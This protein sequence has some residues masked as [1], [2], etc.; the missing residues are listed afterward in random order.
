[1]NLASK[2]LIHTTTGLARGRHVYFNKHK[3][4]TDPAKQDPDYFEKMARTLP[5]DDNYIDQ[6]KKIY[7]D[8]I[9]SE[10]DLTMKASD[11]LVADKITYGLPQ[12]DLSKPRP[13]YSYVDSLKDAPESVR[14]IFSLEFGTRRDV[15]SEWKRV[16]IESVNHHTLDNSSLE[17]KI[18]LCTALIRHWSMIVDEIFA[19]N[20]RPRKP[21]WLTHRIWLVIGQRR[22]LL[23]ELREINEESFQRVLKELKIAYHVQKQPE[24]VKTRKAWSEAQLL[25]RIQEEKEK[26]LE[27]LH[28]SYIKEREEK[29]VEMNERK[30]ELEKE[31]IDI[32]QRMK[33]LLILEGKA[34]D[35]VVGEYHPSLVGNM[36]ETVVHSML[37]YHPKPDMVRNN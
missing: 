6:L 21:S 14:K 11:N 32:E 12:L 5:L 13:P 18:A 35:N 31:K 4:V 8:K 2:R 19:K 30:K 23:R 15:T 7:D 16:M 29:M 24:H 25:L 28:Q 10:R 22:R 9:G 27:E 20:H 26:R 3:M 1:M 34:T 36:T 37:F 33:E 17:K